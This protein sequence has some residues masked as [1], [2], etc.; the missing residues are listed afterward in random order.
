MK[1]QAYIIFIIAFVISF[2]YLG[3]VKPILDDKEDAIRLRNDFLDNCMKD[4]INESKCISIY[5]ANPSIPNL[6]EQNSKV[7]E[8]IL[9]FLIAFIITLS[10]NL[11]IRGSNY[12]NENL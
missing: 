4:G 11:L 9:S 8:I 3:M 2:T 12:L 6:Y 7:D 10:L 1:N 5:D